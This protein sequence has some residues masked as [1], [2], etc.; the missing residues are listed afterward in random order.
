MRNYP[1][2]NLNPQATVKVLPIIHLALLIGQVLFATVVY[3]ITP[4]K[5]FSLNGNDPFIF[6][7][8]A[9]AAGG[10]I[11][12]NIIYKQTLSKIAPDATLSQKVSAYQTAF[13]IRAALMESPSL[14]SIVAYM[15][16]GNL[17][18]LAL[19]VLIVLYFITL[20]PTKD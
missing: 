19:T 15:L 10:F 17:F 18:F 8:L 11:G 1:N 3:F 4:Q 13:I 6:V 14:F 12:G 2:P 5:G 7:G 20:R 16:G 9:L